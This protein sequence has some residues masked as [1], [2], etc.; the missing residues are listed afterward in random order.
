MVM[1]FGG[2][3]ARG[4]SEWRHGDTGVSVPVAAVAWEEGGGYELL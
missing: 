1:L 2:G 4:N 3:D